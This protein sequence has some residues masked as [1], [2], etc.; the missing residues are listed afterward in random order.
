MS[1]YVI[2][3]IGPVSNRNAFAPAFLASNNF[4]TRKHHNFNRKYFTLVLFTYG[5]TGNSNTAVN[6][7]HVVPQTILCVKTGQVSTVNRPA[8][9]PTLLWCPVTCKKNNAI[10][11]GTILSDAVTQLYYYNKRG[12]IFHNQ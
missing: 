2:R 10:Y 5:S 8:S 12:T 6:L 3:R 11:F 1:I 7:R 4:S 9:G